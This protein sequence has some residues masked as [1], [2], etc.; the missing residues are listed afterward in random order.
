MT[1]SSKALKLKAFRDVTLGPPAKAMVELH[2]LLAS[3]AMVA[4]VF[5]MAEK[6]LGFSG[7]LL[8]VQ[9]PVVANHG[10]ACMMVCCGHDCTCRADICA[11]Y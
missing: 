9:G 10:L 1:I 4:F 8:A 5:L 3:F 2:K 11:A 7:S 6:K